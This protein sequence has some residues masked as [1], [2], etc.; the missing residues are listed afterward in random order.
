MILRYILVLAIGA[1]TTL[2]LT[3]LVRAFCIGRG[4][5]DLPEARRV[6]RVPTPRLGGTADEATARGIYARWIGM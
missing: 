4:W 6:H 5:Y 3:P 2:L 1:A